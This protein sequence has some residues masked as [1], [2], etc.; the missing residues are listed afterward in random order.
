MFTRESA[1]VG[2]HI[3]SRTAANTPLH[4]VMI[5]EISAG[6]SFNPFRFLCVCLHSYNSEGGKVN[7]LAQSQL[8]ES[9]I[10]FHA[11]TGLQCTLAQKYAPGNLDNIKLTTRK[12]LAQFIRIFTNI[13]N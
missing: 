12:N 7:T 5:S 8:S 10:V 11:T 4:L 13:H 2:V 3:A 6:N 1:S 9:P